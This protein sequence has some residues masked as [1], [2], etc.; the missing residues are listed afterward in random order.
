MMELL[1][2]YIIGAIK[3]TSA[4]QDATEPTDGPPNLTGEREKARRRTEPR[5]VWHPPLEA[6]RELPV[7]K[8]DGG[9]LQY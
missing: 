8:A 5:R 6:R 9:V 7:V 1:Q 2:H 4:H 3:S